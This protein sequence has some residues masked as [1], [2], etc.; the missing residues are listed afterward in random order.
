[1]AEFIQCFRFFFSSCHLSHAST[2]EKETA[3]ISILILDPACSRVCPPEKKYLQA[4]RDPNK[5][6]GPGFFF[7]SFLGS[8]QTFFHC[9][10]QVAYLLQKKKTAVERRQE[11]RNSGSEVELKHELLSYSVLRAPRI[12][13]PWYCSKRVAVECS[14]V[15]TRPRSTVRRR[16]RVQMKKEEKKKK[17]QVTKPEPLN[18]WITIRSD[19]E[20]I[21]CKTAVQG[22]PRE[23]FLSVAQC[24]M[25][26]TCVI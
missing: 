8:T 26:G 13:V 2:I 7:W 10:S 9:R 3:I 1:M 12:I 16:R 17:K 5:G 25:L 21:L 22:F 4:P 18:S 6:Q 15:R 14:F 23:G 19:P 11:W 24:Y 20:P